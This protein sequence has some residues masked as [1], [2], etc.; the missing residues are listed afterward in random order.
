MRALV[1]SKSDGPVKIP[2]ALHVVDLPVPDP[3]DEALIKVT[4]AG[5]CNTDLEIVKGY[6][7]FQGVPGHE[8]VGV[9]HESPD[10]AWVGARVVGEINAG[11]GRCALCKK[12]DPRHCP[13]RTVLGILGRQGVFAQYVTL[14]LANLHRVPDAVFD[15]AAVFVEPLAAACRIVEQIEIADRD[16]LVVGDGKL[17]QLIAPVLVANDARCTVVGKHATKLALVPRECK[18][19]LLADLPGQADFEIVVEASGS[20]Q[21]FALAMERVKPGG[22]IVLKS[23]CAHAQPI[24]MAPLVVREIQ[25]LGSRCGRFEPALRLL[26]QGKVDPRP[27]ISHRLSLQQAI[28]G[29]ALAGRPE[30]MKV[31]LEMH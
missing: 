7:D 12:G 2:D 26:E 8:F 14:P 9:V 10:P 11:C 22:T 19:F 15:E 5:I 24:N 1:F 31:L 25:V 29:F 6:M 3:M 30:T 13:E 23:T 18:T 4:L 27:L 17:A 28:E 16:V 21:G 20:P